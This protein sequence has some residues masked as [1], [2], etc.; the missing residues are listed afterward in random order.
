M[1]GY[2]GLAGALYK[3]V[4]LH[5]NCCFPL[6]VEGYYYW[7]LQWEVAVLYTRPAVPRPRPRPAN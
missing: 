6:D 5:G 4:T 3:H 7:A 1:T 2:I